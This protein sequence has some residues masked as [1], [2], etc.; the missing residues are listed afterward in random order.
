MNSAITAVNILQRQDIVDNDPNDSA[1]TTADG[2][3]LIVLIG[4]S[5]HGN[6][7]NGPGPTPIAGTVFEWNG[8]AEV[9]VTNDDLLLSEN[10]SGVHGPGAGSP[11]PQC[12]VTYNAATSRKPVYVDTHSPGSEFAPNIDNNNWSSTGTLRA[13]ATTKINS[14]I[15]HYEVQRPMVIFVFLGVNDIGGTALIGTIQSDIAAFFVWVQATYPNTPIVCAQP[16]FAGNN[17]ETLRAQQVRTAIKQQAVLNS[18]VH[19][20]ANFGHLDRQSGS[21]HFVQSSN[22]TVGNMASRW[23][24]SSSYSKWARA[25]I[26]SHS[27]DL[28]TTQ[29]DKVQVWVGDGVEYLGIDIFYNWKSANEVDNKND[30]GFGAYLIPVN[31]M[32]F[33]SGVSYQS[34]GNVSGTLSYLRS[35]YVPSGLLNAAVDD[36][37]MGVGIVS[38]ANTVATSLFGVR[39]SG[40]TSEATLEVN[41]AGAK[42]FRIHDVTSTTNAGGF[43]AGSSYYITRN[44][45]TKSLIENT[46][47]VTS[48]TVSSVSIPNIQP[49][50]FA[51]SIA[52]ATNRNG[53]AAFNFFVHGKNSVIGANIH[54]KTQTLLTGW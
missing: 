42:S 13:L 22:N 53:A 29:K 35:V 16:G 23:L 50:I 44:G 51:L 46:T 37:L 45:T 25:I 52:G 6:S 15:A 30:W 17:N 8:S 36:V 14:A 4:D 10:A 40:G 33:N 19:L 49:F 21:S 2:K 18:N 54:A 7:N 43:N 5:M 11:W 28:S 3:Q 9:M 34:P 26:A 24:T 27:I 12:G 38:I 1:Y 31:N 32:V 47:V 48:A 39:I 41:A 20:F